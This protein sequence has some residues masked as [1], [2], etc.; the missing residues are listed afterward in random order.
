MKIKSFVLLIFVLFSCTRK[1]TDEKFIVSLEEKKEKLIFNITFNGQIDFIWN[2][3]V[4]SSDYYS[5]DESSI[6]LSNLNNLDLER[7]Q[8]IIE[9]KNSGK[10]F[11]SNLLEDIIYPVEH[12]EVNEKKKIDLKS[13]ESINF[14]LILPYSYKH[15]YIDTKSIDYEVRFHYCYLSEF[16]LKRITSNWV[17]LY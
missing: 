9:N 17:K 11:F 15:F 8:L 10:R 13:G 2:G 1:E 14:N 16:G 12:Y 5:K 7:S 3:N 6:D 4:L